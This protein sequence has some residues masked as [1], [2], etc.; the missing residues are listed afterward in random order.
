MS[1]NHPLRQRALP[2]VHTVRTVHHSPTA[3]ACARTVRSAQRPQPSPPEGNPSNSAEMWPH[4]PTWASTRPTER[5]WIGRMVPSRRIGQERAA[6][7]VGNRLFACCG[8]EHGGPL[9][10]IRT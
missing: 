4:G 1:D 8:R 2:T 7:T 6:G 9:C 5:A 10:R 3:R